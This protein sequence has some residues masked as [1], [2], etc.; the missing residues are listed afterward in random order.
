MESTIDEVLPKVPQQARITGAET[1]GSSALAVLSPPSAQPDLRKSSM[2]RDT[3]GQPTK[4]DQHA[5][6]SL[7]HETRCAFVSEN[8]SLQR[9]LAT[10]YRTLGDQHL[11]LQQLRSAMHQPNDHPIRVESLSD[12]EDDVV[13]TLSTIDSGNSQAFDIFYDCISRFSMEDLATSVDRLNVNFSGSPRYHFETSSAFFPQQY[14][15]ESLFSEPLIAFAITKS[16]QHLYTQDYYLLYAKT[17]QQ[18]LRV[19]IS[20]TFHN[21]KEQSVI[22][23]AS[24]AR[25]LD[26][27]YRPLPRAFQDAMNKILP[28][29]EFYASVTKISLGLW[30]DCAGKLVIDPQNIRVAED[31][32]EIE[33][34]DEVRMLQDIDDLGCPQYLASE[35]I[36]ISRLTTSSFRVLAEGRMCVEQKMLF[37]T[38]GAEGEN[39]FLAV[40]NDLKRLNS[41][42][43]CPGVVEFNGV[44]LDDTRRHLRSYLY[45]LPV[46]A[47]LQW[48]F[49]AAESRSQLIPWPIRELWARQ[50]I[51]A[52]ANIH[53]RGHVIGLLRLGGIGVRADGTAVITVLKS[54]PYLWHNRRGKW[55]PE[56]RNKSTSTSIPPYDMM[57]FRTDIFQLG[58]VLWQLTQ[59]RCVDG[60]SFCRRSGCTKRFDYTCTAEH[61]NPVK[62]PV[63]GFDMPAPYGDLI[64]QCRALD[65]RC[66]PTAHKL[67]E[68]LPC[69][70]DEPHTAVPGMEEVLATYAEIGNHYAVWCDDCGRSG[71][72]AYYSCN[73][74]KSANYDICGFCY[75][76]GVRCPVP[77]HRLLKRIIKD[78]NIVGVT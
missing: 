55:P 51:H 78:G 57:N 19:T 26:R 5:V 3:Q 71:A 62:L 17:P 66:R 73:V 42:R 28:F 75:A 64:D 63:H 18:C 61:A 46:L 31:R 67:A 16:S 60:I 39:G 11:Q 25:N 43:G 76:Q 48:L 40:F 27:S 32:A 74:C 65:P 53:S 13:D 20:A 22:L 58:L 9:H 38:D 15:T 23:Q 36:M 33:M 12:N 68:I 59:Q 14:A 1:S 7:V 54:S 4:L 24:T 30:E 44:V 45:E 52:V 10:I 77:E 70:T 34:S 2:H 50:I 41:L 29:V 49:S 6:E 8:R 56:W 47:N 72:E 35:I 37:A 21:L 69:S